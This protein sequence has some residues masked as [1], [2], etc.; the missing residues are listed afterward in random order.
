MG[1]F[2]NPPLAENPRKSPVLRHLKNG[3]K[4]ELLCKGSC[5]SLKRSGSKKRRKNV[6]VESSGQG[7]K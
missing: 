5:L 7:E 6:S 4:N 1:G 2:S 3:V